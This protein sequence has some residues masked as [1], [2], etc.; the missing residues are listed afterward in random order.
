MPLKTSLLNKGIIKN[1]IKRLYW[2][3]ILYT[4]ALFFAVPLQIILRLNQFK[5]TVPYK[6]IYGILDFTGGGVQHAFILIVPVLLA[7]LLFNYL[8]TKK[9]SDMLHSLPIKRN[10]L[11][12]SHTLV[13]FLFLTVPVIANGFITW[14]VQIINNLHSFYSL[15]DI[16]LWAAITI[17]MN[18]V[19][20][21]ITVFVGTVTGLTLVQGVLTYIMLFLPM[22]LLFLVVYNMQ[23][24]MY[25]FS[26]RFSLVYQDD[27][28]MI[29]SPFYRI[30]GLYSMEA[31]NLIGYLVLVL[32]LFIGGMYLY[33]KRRLE[34]N[35]QPIVFKNL[36]YLFK[37]GVAFSFM[38]TA[39]MYFQEVGGGIAWI[40]F[41]YAIASFLGYFIA[42]GI[43]QK[44]FRIINRKTLTSYSIYMGT[45]ILLLVGISLDFTGY[46]KR[47]PSS[48][49][50]KG[51]CFATNYYS[52]RHQE[53][54]YLY[55]DP[56]NIQLIS[57]AHK[58]IIG[59]RKN[60]KFSEKVYG[61]NSG[62]LYFVYQLKNGKKI[63]RGYEGIDLSPYMDNIKEINSSIEYKKMHYDVLNVDLSKIEKI[64]FESH[65]DNISKDL[66]IY[67]SDE[68]EE[69][70]K[71]L[72]DEIISSNY[73]ELRDSRVWGVVD[74][75]LKPEPDENT[76]IIEATKKYD[77]YTKEFYESIAVTWYKSFDSI[78]EWLMEK[79]YL[80][81][82]RLVKDEVEFIM[83]NVA[84]SYEEADKILA[85]MGEGR[86][87]KITDKEKIEISLKN[88]ANHWRYEDSPIYVVAFY[89][90]AGDRIDYGSFYQQHVPQFIKEYF[91]D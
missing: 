41:G 50:I 27:L 71:L 28:L 70:T 80:E 9:S 20:F 43:L 29:L 79:G 21:M 55:K 90:E 64:T 26:W 23:S 85:S 65:H 51:V 36:S 49:E 14:I 33:Q 12:T 78:D 17:V 4:I 48:D 76:N 11:F 8:Q 31:K 84:D 73:D 30:I 72:Q 25:G 54:K 69:L 58:E 5:E 66:V 53:D 77:K 18:M 32:V 62:N 83:V 47:L 39:G 87:L 45:V 59:N 88:Y 35:M 81:E 82:A 86:S 2:F 38:L 24:L 40:L 52:Y 37:Y 19:I 75:L 6:H 13:G 46:E 63:T 22:G 67:D 10:T 16:L 68:I 89:N 44:S 74:L 61:E 57:N 60:M 15:E 3:P 56:K 91:E 42:E 7:L 34:N 1:D